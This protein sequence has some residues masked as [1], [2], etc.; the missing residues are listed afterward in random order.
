MTRRSL[1]SL[2][3][4]LL[5]FGFS[6]WMLLPIQSTVELVYQ[7][8]YSDNATAEEKTAILADALSVIQNSID[9]STTKGT[10][11]ATGDDRITVE[12]SGLNDVDFAGNLIGEVDNFTLTEGKVHGERLGRSGLRLGLDLQGGVHLLYQA[13]LSSVEPG[14]ESDIMKGIEAVISNRINPLGVTE[15]IIVVQGTDRLRVDL[16]GLSITEKEKQRL[17]SV[18]LLE[19]GELTT[20]NASAKWTNELGMWEPATAVIDGEEKELT[21]RY[22]NQNTYV[23]T[24]SMGAIELYFQWDS[25]GQ[26]ISEEVTSRLLGQRLGIFEGDSSLYGEDGQPIAPVVQAV[27]TEGGRITGLSLEEATSL[28]QQLNAGRLPVS[29][30]V[31]SDETVSPLLGASFV[32]MAWKAGIIGIVL[33]MLF[34]IVYYRFPGFLSSLALIYYGAL[35]L[36]LFKLIPVT[37]TLAGLGGF[38]LSIGMA[39]DANV[40]IF[41]RMKEEFRMGR[42]LSAA[43]ESGFNRAWSAIRDSNITTIIVCIILFW[44]GSSIDSGAPVKGFALTLGIGVIVSMLTAII[45]TRTL[46]RIFVTTTLT[47]KPALFNIDRIDRG[48]K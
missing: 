32:E 40:L 48:N 15:P 9:A 4:I 14:S 21:S 47:K 31:I 2:I 8:Q 44:V 42:T 10:V 1:I 7:A 45:V 36:A 27:I 20:D 5:V 13:D 24:D 46:L 16:P 34:M 33:V 26:K 6:L 35:V 39:V 29:L 18:A 23:G 43:V 25:E 41:E 19:F 17:S 30:K 3:I 11:E 22:F 37:L 12:L 28:S 38:I